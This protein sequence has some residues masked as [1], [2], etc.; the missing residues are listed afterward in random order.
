MLSLALCS[1]GGGQRE[2]ETDTEANVRRQLRSMHKRGGERER[3]RREMECCFLSSV[4]RQKK[5][6]RRGLRDVVCRSTTTSEKEEKRK[7]HGTARRGDERRT[8]SRVSSGI[9]FTPLSDR[10]DQ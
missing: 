4:S 9:D 2:T 5:H 7:P 10:Q 6:S 3:E 1:E 8:G